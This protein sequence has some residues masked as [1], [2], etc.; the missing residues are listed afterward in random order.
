MQEEV[1][2]GLMALVDSETGQRPVSHV[3]FSEDVCREGARTR[4][5][6][7]LAFLLPDYGATARVTG[8]ILR[9]MP[10][11]PSGYHEPDGILV[12]TGLGVTSGTHGVANISEVAPT[13][14]AAF[15]VAATAHIDTAPI[16]WLVHRSE[17]L[18]HVRSQP[19]EPRAPAGAGLTAAEQDLM[20]QHLRDLGYVD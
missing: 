20:E 14:L 10:P 8:D 6:E 7:L 12:A 13:I 11:G 17:V 4:Y 3:V 15:G 18:Q 9:P 2:T 1:A 16:P 19:S 5:P